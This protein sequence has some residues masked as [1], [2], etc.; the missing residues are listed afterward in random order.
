MGEDFL[1]TYQP[2]GGG[3]IEPFLDVGPTISWSAE[4]EVLDPLHDVH[5]V[6]GRDVVVMLP[7]DVLLPASGRV[8]N[9]GAESRVIHCKFS[10]GTSRRF[11]RSKCSYLLT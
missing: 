2:G 5:R 8:R 11:G 9:T 4:A 6:G 3:V 1:C 7:E 10:Q